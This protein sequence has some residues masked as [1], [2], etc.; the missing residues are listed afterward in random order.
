MSSTEYSWAGVEGAGI[1]NVAA[2]IVNLL[3]FEAPAD[4]D[5]SL[6][7]ISG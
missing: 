3:G 7:S 2:T 5:T 1:S 6:I 4:Y